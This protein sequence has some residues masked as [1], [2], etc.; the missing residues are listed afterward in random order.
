MSATADLAGLLNDGTE[1][2]LLTQASTPTEARLIREQIAA[3]GGTGR[4]V[5]DLGP[6]GS[7]RLPESLLE[8]S[9]VRLVPVPG[10]WLPPAH[11]GLRAARVGD[12]VAGHDPYPPT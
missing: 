10:A 6:R 4:V 2:V 12:I 1:T 7:G 3:A 8:D 11:D 9:E 5:V